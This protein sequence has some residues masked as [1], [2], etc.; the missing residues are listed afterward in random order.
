MKLTYTSPKGVPD[1][2]SL[3]QKYFDYIIDIVQ[4]RSYAYGFEKI[5]LP[6]FEDARLYQKGTGLSTDVVQKE[7]Y[8]VNLMHHHTKEEKEEKII[9]A[10]RPEFTPGAVRAYLEHAMFTKPQPVKLLSIGE[11]F[12]HDKP[13]KG[14]FRQFN[15]FNLEV[16]GSNDSLTDALLILMI[17]QIYKDL[18]LQDDIV[19][20]INNI[21]CNKCQPIIRKKLLENIEKI[22]TKLC[23]TCQER[24]Y[25]NPLRILDC[26]NQNCHKQVMNLPHIIDLICSSCRKQFM[27]VLEYLDELQVPYDLNPYLVRG[28]DYYTSTTFEI[29]DKKDP[30]KLTSL[31]GGGRYDGLIKLYGGQN[32]PAIGFAGGIERI[33]D[34][35][36][37]KEI[38][39]PENNKVDIFI[40][41]LGPK[42]KKFALNLISELTNK[43]YHVS[44]ALGK[45]TLSSQLKIANKVKAKLSVIIGQREMLDKTVIVKDMLETSQE[46][47]EQSDLEDYLKLKLNA[48]EKN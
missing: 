38:K 4:K 3:E 22:Q 29:I 20:E 35:L 37:E 14:R 1:I 8:Q 17:W 16:I 31:G 15:Q 18:K 47:I 13:Q 23:Q 6:I 5:S 28:F 39:L 10:L 33:I 34:K 32:I 44:C 25:S 26:K 41:Q 27:S 30:K 42:A 12:R 19:I 45:S 21:G 2:L 40:V 48:K 24:L 43:S 7:M 9:Y 36:K 46:I 11:L